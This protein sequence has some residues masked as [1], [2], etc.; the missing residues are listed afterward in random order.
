VDKNINIYACLFAGGHQTF[1]A[2]KVCKNAR[3]SRYVPFHSLWLIKKT[4]ALRFVS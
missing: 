1:E 3:Q 2:S 4:A